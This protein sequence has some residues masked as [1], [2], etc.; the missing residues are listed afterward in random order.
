MSI[1]KIQ[2]FWTFLAIV[3]LA[4]AAR[5]ILALS[6]DGYWGVDGG[7]SILSANYVMGSEPTGAGFPKPPLAPGYTL[8]PFVA[9]LGV[10][11][12]YKVW[13]ALFAVLVL[14]PVYLLTRR[15]VGPWPAVGT[16]LFAAVD[17][18]WAEMFVTGSHP[19]IAFALMGMAWYSMAAKADQTTN[20]WTRHD[21]IIMASIGLIP[22]V[23][24]TTA[25]LAIIILP[26]YFA[27]LCWFRRQVLIRVMVPCILAG[28]IAIGALPWYMQ[29]L[30]GSA[31]LTYGGPILYWAWGINTVQGFVIALPLGIYAI[32]KIPDYR[33]KSLGVVLLALAGLMQWL[34]FDEVLINP[35][36]RARYLLALAF[37]PVM[38]WVV[39]RVWMPKVQAWWLELWL[40]ISSGPLRAQRKEP[41]RERGGRHT[42]IVCATI[43][44]FVYMAS[45][46]VWVVQEQARLSEMVTPETATI[47]ERLRDNDDSHGIATNA[48]SLSLWVAGLNR[49]PS[50]FLFTA[51]PPPAYIESDRL[52]RC[53][54]GWVPD[55][56][57][58]QAAGIL[59]IQYIL[60][61]ERF[62][63][64]NQLA[65]GNY[66][67][68]PNQW[69]TTANTEWLDLVYREG[70]T[71]LYEVRD[72]GE[73]GT[74][75]PEIYDHSGSGH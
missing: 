13:S 43:L 26:V 3:G 56:D 22:W 5:L 62:P 37:Y 12:G 36:Y 67:A 38:A 24:Q 63:F 72:D 52:L 20:H 27:A 34:S 33:I 9:L 30:P 61:D 54:V 4:L 60:I 17:W 14:F 46:W 66:M 18:T 40:D 8:V 58:R 6:W 1:N 53:S 35:P 2:P 45:V 25:G 71:R 75:I 15:Y 47:L 32:W 11:V 68:P 48:F 7:A 42:I 65:P 50:P 57:G 28:I 39:F 23:N 49:V 31:T 64:Y 69:Q 51:H 55:C 44:A 74:A 70:T 73:F 19:L 10:D 29:T 41:L 59:G 21:W 16:A